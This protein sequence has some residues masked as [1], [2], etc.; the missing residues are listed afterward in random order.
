M[1]AEL[2]VEKS[3]CPRIAGIIRSLYRNKPKQVEV[4]ALPILWELIKSPSQTQSDAELRRAVHD[5]A[6]LL[7]DCFGEKT[8]LEMANS[9]LNP[10]Q[11]KTLEALIK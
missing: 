4:T 10:N 2:F 1:T 6:S 9:H 3:G 5:Y 8:L 11:K 7:R